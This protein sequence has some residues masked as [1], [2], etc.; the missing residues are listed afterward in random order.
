MRATVT[1]ITSL[2]LIEPLNKNNFNRPLSQKWIYL[3]VVTNQC[4]GTPCLAIYLT[5]RCRPL[6]VFLRQ[7]L[8]SVFPPDLSFSSWANLAILFYVTTYHQHHIIFWS[9][10][11]Y[12]DLMTFPLISPFE[13]L[14]TIRPTAFASISEFSHVFNNFSEWVNLGWSKTLLQ[15]KTNI[16]TE[17]AVKN[18][19][20][21]RLH[22]S[23]K[24]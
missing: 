14:S 24:C 9:K 22:D 23:K 13:S 11:I 8:W 19:S 1:R 17:T 16:A 12:I 6:A 18:L 15:E 21:G 10:C 20:H 7:S 4:S 2:I 3:A 5:G